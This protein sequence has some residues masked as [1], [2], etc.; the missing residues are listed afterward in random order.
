MTEES[1]VNGM[2]ALT[3][4]SVIAADGPDAAAFLHGQL[5]QDVVLLGAHEGRLAAYCSAKGRMLASFYVLKPSPERVLL[6]CRRDVLAPTLKRLG[7]FVL[8]AKV[9]LSDA[10]A[11]LSLHGLINQPG[12]A[13]SALGAATWSSCTDEHGTSWLRLPDAPQGVRVLR[14]GADCTSPDTPACAPAGS[15]NESVWDW[16]EVRSGVALI[17]QA[18]SEALVPQ[19]LNYESVGGVSFKKGCYPGQEVV[20]R[21]QFRGTLKRRGYLIH[22]LAPLLAGQP[23][24]LASTVAATI[25][26]GDESQPEPCGVVVQAAQAPGGGWDAMVSLQVSA[27]ASDEVSGGVVS[28]PGQPVELLALPYSLLDDI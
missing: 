13:P 14:V 20:A 16:L 7:L 24:Y 27:A 26:V 10:S 18:V 23:L 17:T 22:S 6:V 21:S 15:A 1:T 28:A 11:S 19:M 8:R 12:A 9:K 4:W 3:Q 2:P 5:T 25:G